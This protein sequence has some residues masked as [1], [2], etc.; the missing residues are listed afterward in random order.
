MVSLIK[1]HESSTTAYRHLPLGLLYDMHTTSTKLV[2]NLESQTQPM[3]LTLHLASPPADKLL[4]LPSQENCKQMFMAQLKEADFLR[5]GSTKRVTGLRK[6]DQDG[7][8]ESIREREFGI[9][10]A[11]SLSFEMSNL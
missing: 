6:Q 10:L 1:W 2:S 5:W 11:D 3:R 4:M 8:W 9:Q 7:L